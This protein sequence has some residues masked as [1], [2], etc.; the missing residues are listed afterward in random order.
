VPLGGISTRIRL[1]C[2]IPWARKTAAE[3]LAEAAA[4]L[5]EGIFLVVGTALRSL[6]MQ[7]K[8]YRRYSRILRRRHPDWPP[9]VLRREANRFLHPPDSISPPGHCT[10]GAF[11]VVLAYANGRQV[12]T[13]SSTIPEARTWATFYP[14][15]TPKARANRALLYTVMIEAGFTNCY[16]EWWHYSYGDTGWAA[17]AGKPCAI[18][19]LP[20]DLSPTL[21]QSIARAERK[22][23]RRFRL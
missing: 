19:G 17:R 6:K 16:E 8:S 14:H 15:L 10:G 23:P 4:H 2:P 13:F 21:L 9:G 3:M 7:A 5:P 1:K 11:D 18:Y 22:P 20:T 12:D